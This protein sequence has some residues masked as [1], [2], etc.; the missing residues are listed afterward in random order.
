MK[1][2]QLNRGFIALV[3]DEDHE[4]IS[5]HHWIIKEDALG[6]RYAQRT[7]P[8]GIVL[9]HREIMGMPSG[10]DVHHID[11]YGLNNCKSNLII[12]SHQ[13]NM[14]SRKLNINSTT[15]YKGVWYRKDNGMW[16]SV[17]K[18]NGKN[19][20]L[21]SFDNI[22]EAARVYD[23]AAVQHFGKFAFTNADMRNVLAL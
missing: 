23:D 6:Y 22:L 1:E 2:I 8:N 4:R 13:Q 12:C 10:M 9:M 19:I 14:A 7:I 15:G 3:D 20:C 18:V 17:I 21:G 5:S 11:H 16:R